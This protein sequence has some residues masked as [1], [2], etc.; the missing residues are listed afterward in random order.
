MIGHI[1]TTDQDNSLPEHIAA[2]HQGL[3]NGM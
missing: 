2:F 3:Y 1:H